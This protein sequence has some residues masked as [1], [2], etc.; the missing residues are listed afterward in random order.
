MN[1][2]TPLRDDRIRTIEKPFAWL[3]CRILVSGLFSRLSDDAKL[4]YLFLCLAADR[5]G[6]SFYGDQRIQSFFQIQAPAIHQAKQELI[7]KDLIAYDGYLYQVLSLPGPITNPIIHKE[8]T[9]E[10]ERLQDILS[11]LTNAT[12]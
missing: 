5:Q 10:P 3:P 6:L 12:R 11:R 1:P 9:S 7:Q 8:R 4:L 2:K